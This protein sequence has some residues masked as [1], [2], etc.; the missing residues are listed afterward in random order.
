MAHE[1]R[2]LV[3]ELQGA[4]ELVRAHALLAGVEQVEGHR[5][6]IQRGRRRHASNRANPG[7]ADL[8]L[9]AFWS[10]LFSHAFTTFQEGQ[11]CRQMCGLPFWGSR[12]LHD[13]IPN[14]RHLNPG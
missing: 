13:V 6:L 3:I 10:P 8:L 12:T 1:P 7:R 2:R 14:C 11:Q 5:P 9:P 4:V